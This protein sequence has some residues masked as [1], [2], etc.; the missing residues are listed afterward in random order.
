MDKYEYLA[1]EDLGLKP[2]NVEEA[3]FD[4]SPLGNIWRLKEEAKKKDFWRD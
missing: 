4:Y 1:G 2:S 3:K